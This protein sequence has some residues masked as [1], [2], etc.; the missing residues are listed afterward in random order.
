[1]GESMERFTDEEMAF[2]RHVRFGELPAPV[3]PEERVELTETE[4]RRDRPDDPPGPDDS[5]YPYWAAG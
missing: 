2:L 1:M 4:A 3:R 5:V